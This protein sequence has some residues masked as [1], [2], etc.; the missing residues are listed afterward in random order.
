MIAIKMQAFFY[1]GSLSLKQTIG[2]ESSYTKSY[3]GWYKPESINVTGLD[4]TVKCAERN[5]S[6]PACNETTSPCLFNVIEDPCEYNNIAHQYPQ[7]VKSMMKKMLNFAH[8]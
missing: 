3:G 2:P 4:L 5:D 8:M 1:V 6:L 7:L